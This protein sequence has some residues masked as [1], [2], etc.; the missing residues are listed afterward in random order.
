MTRMDLRLRALR[1]T[2]K[3]ISNDG[4]ATMAEKTWTEMDGW[5]KA[6]EVTKVVGGVVVVALTIWGML[7]GYGPT[8]KRIPTRRMAGGGSSVSGGGGTSVWTGG[9]GGKKG[10]GSWSSFRHS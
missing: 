1:L 4:S 7:L 2:T 10:Y 9:H 8:I 6:W 3:A 5:D